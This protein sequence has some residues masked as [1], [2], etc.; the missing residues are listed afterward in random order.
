MSLRLFTVL[1]INLLFLSTGLPGGSVHS[2]IVSSSLFMMKY[3]NFSSAGTLEV[4]VLLSIEF[5]K[6]FHQSPLSMTWK[7]CWHRLSLLVF[8]LQV[9]W[10]RR[11]IIDRWS[12]FAQPPHILHLFLPPVT[13]SLARH[14]SRCP[15]P[16]KTKAALKQFSSQLPQRLK[17]A[18]HLYNFLHWHPLHSSLLLWYSLHV[19]SHCCVHK[20]IYLP[21]G[22]CILCM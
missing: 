10:K 19:F 4:S 14:T 22:S 16:L 11:H 20:P 21:N 18:K 17:T 12:I 5:N 15:N 3:E 1:F 2:P 6:E 7:Q 13:P 9:G 8:A